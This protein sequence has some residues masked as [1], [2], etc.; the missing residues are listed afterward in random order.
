[1]NGFERIHVV[2]NDPR[3]VIAAADV[4]VSHGGPSTV[5][6]ARMAGA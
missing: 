3:T 5:M 4:V 2:S 6:D 1:M